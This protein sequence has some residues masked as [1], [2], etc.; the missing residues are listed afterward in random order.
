[1]RHF[2]IASAAVLIAG[3]VGAAQAGGFS[4]GT[5]DT[6]ILFEDGK[7]NFRAGVTVVVPTQEITSAPALQGT[8]GLVGSDYLGTYAIPSG[9]VKV[10]VSEN[11]SC[12][13]TYTDAYGAA[14]GYVVPYGFSGKTHEVF[15]ITEFGATCAVFFDVGKGRFS[16]LGGGFVERFKYELRSNPVPLGGL[17]LNIDLSSNAPG[18]RAGVAYEIPEIAFRTQLMYRSGTDHDA[19]G[20]GTFGHPLGTI[21]LVATGRGKLPQSVELKVQSGIAPGWL[22]FGSVK[23]TDWSVN[24]TLDLSFSGPI[25]GTNDS[26]NQYYWKDGWTITGGIAHAFNEN[27]SGLASVTWDSG[28]ATGYDFRS[29]K[30]LF[31][32][33]VS[34]KDAMGGELRLGGGVSYLTSA[35]IDAVDAINR[36]AAADSGWAGIVSANYKIKW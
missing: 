13:G 19:D 9:A 24:E 20:S 2:R 14:S 18:W 27:I 23:W 26:L 4:R 1:M 25:V 12:A 8:P 7:I 22:A 29:D 17:P 34:V 11:L 6:D 28:V 16:V 30:W 33:G 36:G 21:P 32:A 35:T 5:A 31:A 3:S 10:R 15:T